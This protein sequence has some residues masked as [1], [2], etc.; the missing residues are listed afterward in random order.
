MH[1]TEMINEMSRQFWNSAVLRACIKLELF[2]LVES[3][4]A[5]SATDIAAHLGGDERFVNALAT[6][7]A[8]LDLLES[9]DDD[10]FTL[11]PAARQFLLPEAP[12]YVGNLVL[13]IT[14]YWSTWGNLDQL[15]LDGRTELPFQNGYSSEAD[16]WRDYMAGQHDRAVAG[17]GHHLAQAVDLSNHN[18][19]LDLGGGAASYS[20]ALCQANPHLHS[21]VIDAPEPLAI[22]SPLVAEAGLEDRV[23]LVEGDLFDG[24][25]PTGAD[26]VL[27]SGV[28]LIKSEAECR[29]LF[30]RAHDALGPSGLM[31]LQ[32]F[33]RLDDSPRRRFL[34]T[35][36]DLYVLIGFDPGS[37]DRPGAIYEQ[38]L[39]D[40]GFTDV[41]GT[42]LPT[43]LAVITAQ[44][45]QDG[46]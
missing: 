46:R 37:A 13:H 38:W 3:K 12:D 5:L 18:L 29:T 45:R 27:L 41:K 33:M 1:P 26:V 2:G 34:D 19:L 10:R 43:Q 14:N 40:A 21:I 30:E 17:Q 4:R 6:A 20:I 8:A 35:M 28:V 22:A 44:K 16:Y 36:M 32:D 9:E 31:I 7:A 15:V 23:T 39:T 24:D 25:L 11:T 42:P